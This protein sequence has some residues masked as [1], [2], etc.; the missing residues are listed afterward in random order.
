MHSG[1]SGWALYLPSFAP[2]QPASQQPANWHLSANACEAPRDKPP[3]SKRRGWARFLTFLAVGRLSI[4]LLGGFLTFAQYVD[5]I[6]PPDTLPVA[7]GIVVWTGKGGGRLQ[8]GAE[9]LQSEKGERLLISGVHESNGTAQISELTGLSAK[10]LG[11]LLLSIWIM[12]PKTPSGMHAR[13]PVGRRHWIMIT[14]FSSHPPITCRAPKSK[15]RAPQDAFGSRPI[16]LSAQIIGNGISRLTAPNACSRNIRNFD[17]L[18][19]R[20]RNAEINAPRS[21]KDIPE[22]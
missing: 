17:L 3:Q 1:L 18:R 15:S 5:R 19:P 7:D 6:Q 14:S 2:P 10:S 9:L 8:A 20:A 12:R 11:G 21:C 13:Q 22:T 16:L 4:L